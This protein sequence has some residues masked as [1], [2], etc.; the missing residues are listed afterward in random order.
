MRRN[1]AGELDEV[2]GQGA[3]TPASSPRPAR[4]RR[5][6]RVV[7]ARRDRPR[8]RPRAATGRSPPTCCASC[9]MSASP[10][11]TGRRCGHAAPDRRGAE[12][13]P[14]RPIPTEEVEQAREL[15]RWLADDHFTFLGYREY[16]LPEDGPTPCRRPGH[17][18]RHPALRPAAR[19]GGLRLSQSGQ[20][21]WPAPR[22][23]HKLLILTKANSRATVHRRPTSTTSASRSSTGRQRHR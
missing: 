4:L 15:L 12:P 1:A 2:L 10:S 5:G 7:D 23:E 22:P 21:R 11:R 9:P 3:R 19:R 17:R 18:P 14:P 13:S 6:P 20:R 16:H 8:E